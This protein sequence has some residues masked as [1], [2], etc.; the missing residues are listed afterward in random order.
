MITPVTL[1][2]TFLGGI[3]FAACIRLILGGLQDS[4]HAAATQ[5]YWRRF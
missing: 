5:Q 3:A 4:R 2:S 1:R